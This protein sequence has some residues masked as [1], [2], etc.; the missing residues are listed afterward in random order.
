LD[1]HLRD[2]DRRAKELV[3]KWIAP[4]QMSFTFF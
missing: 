3:E 2:V 4:T 1:A